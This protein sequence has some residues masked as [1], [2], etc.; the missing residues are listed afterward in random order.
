MGRRCHDQRLH[1]DHV[2]RGKKVIVATSTSPRR[3]TG[4]DFVGRDVVEVVRG[5]RDRGRH[6]FLFGGGVLVRSFLAA[7]AV[8]E[9]TVGI[10]PVLLGGGRPLFT[11]GHPP[12]SA[13]GDQPHF[14]AGHPPRELRLADYAVRDGKIRLAYVHR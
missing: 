4:V 10:V 8:D 2:T 13:A 6:C 12:H 11:G 1:R 7:D 5:L 3:E 9:L 14:V